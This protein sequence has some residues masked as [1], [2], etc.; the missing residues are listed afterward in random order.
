MKL[1]H[2][3]FLHDVH[4]SRRSVESWKTHWNGTIASLQRKNGSGRPAILTRTEVQR[5]IAAPIRKLNRSAKKAK[6]TKIATAVRLKSGKQVS[7][8]TIQRIGKEQLG[9]RH[10][11]GK[12]RTA[13]ECQ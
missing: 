11:K 6:Y 1:S 7:D 2:R 5:H 10:I 8:R 12:K 4:A 9:G 3:F 13:E